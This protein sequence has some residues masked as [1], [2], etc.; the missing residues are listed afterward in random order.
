M[1]ASTP[2]LFFFNLKWHSPSFQEK[3]AIVNYFFIRIA[4]FVYFLIFFSVRE[5]PSSRQLAQVLG[6]ADS[7]PLALFLTY[8]HSLIHVRHAADPA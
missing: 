4:F 7:L 6:A 3:G 2:V 8:T 5:P 1:K